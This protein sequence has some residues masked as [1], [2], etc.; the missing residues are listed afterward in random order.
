MKILIIIAFLSVFTANSFSNTI[1]FPEITEADVLADKITDDKGLAGL[2]ESTI[3]ELPADP[4][5]PF[6]DGV[7]TWWQQLRMTEKEKFGAAARVK[8]LLL[9]EFK[10]LAYR[11]QDI[12]D[13]PHVGSNLYV[14]FATYPNAARKIDKVIK[15]QIESSGDNPS[16]SLIRLLDVIV[17]EA[18]IERAYQGAADLLTRYDIIDPRFIETY[19]ESAN[20][21]PESAQ[22]YVTQKKGY[23]VSREKGFSSSTAEWMQLFLHFKNHTFA[24]VELIAKIPIELWNMPVERKRIESFIKLYGESVITGA[25]RFDI[26]KDLYEIN[27]AAIR[28]IV[29]ELDA[30]DHSNFKNVLMFLRDHHAELDDELRIKM[31]GYFSREQVLSNLQE[32]W[33]EAYN[34]ISKDIPT[35]PLE[36][37]EF[38]KETQNGAKQLLALKTLALQDLDSPT[39]HLMDAALY[40]VR[41]SLEM[42]LVQNIE[43]VRSTSSQAK[44]KDTEAIAKWSLILMDKLSLRSDK[45][46]NLLF[47]MSGDIYSDDFEI[48]QGTM[49]RK[50]G[51][52]EIQPNPALFEE[53]TD[54]R[55]DL[56]AIMQL[57]GGRAHTPPQEN[58][59][60]INIS[61]FQPKTPV[62]KARL[63]QGQ[64]I[65]HCKFML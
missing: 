12:L 6:I 29:E 20:I 47:R 37:A 33:P 54:P 36:L 13:I 25:Q 30:Q 2:E 46:D 15:E 35:E 1:P 64:V 27:P 9:E 17:M 4:A 31:E 38:I 60:V 48:I 28:L 49:R 3:S 24:T 21:H 44:S 18:A 8:Y 42:H 56:H 59:E 16:P 61:D 7:K 40:Q 62:K 57:Y 5:P 10:P 52:S 32:V 11:I 23:T 34:T 22:D 55:A 45:V 53:R 63:G 26:W 14:Y 39:L 51:I 50:W 41:T 19:A 58:G 65:H 43:Q